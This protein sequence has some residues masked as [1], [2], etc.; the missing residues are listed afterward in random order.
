MNTRDRV[1]GSEADRSGDEPRLA[2]E[3]KTAGFFERA[4]RRVQRA[5]SRA[6]FGRRARRFEGE[7]GFQ[8][9]RWDDRLYASS[10]DRPGFEGERGER[11]RDARGPDIERGFGSGRD[12][13]HGYG[14]DADYRDRDDLDRGWGR[15]R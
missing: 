13:E 7:R 2:T 10:S 1:T 15:G 4:A 9:G 6:P 11:M 8:R 12:I 3:R 14:A 5:A